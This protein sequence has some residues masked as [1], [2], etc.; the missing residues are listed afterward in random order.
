[1]SSTPQDLWRW[2]R[3]HRW[4]FFGGWL[5]FLPYVML[6]TALARHLPGSGRAEPFLIVPYAVVWIVNGFAISLF[7]CPRCGNRFLMRNTGFTYSNA[8]A[9]RCLTCG[10]RAYEPIDPALVETVPF[11]L[12]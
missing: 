7:R 6:A 9:K 3:I 4:I 12:F 10:Q 2:F 1:M 5:G 11:R 8:F